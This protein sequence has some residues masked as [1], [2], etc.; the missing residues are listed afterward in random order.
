MFDFRRIT[1][2]CL[3]KRLSKHKWPYFLK[4][5]RAWPLWP[6]GY[7]CVHNPGEH[8]GLTFWNMLTLNYTRKENEHKVRKKLPFFNMWLLYVQL[9]AEQNRYGLVW[10]IMINQPEL[11]M[12][13]MMHILQAQV[14]GSISAHPA[15][16]NHKTKGETSDASNCQLNQA[17]WNR[18]VLKFGSENQLNAHNFTSIVFLFSL[19]RTIWKKSRHYQFDWVFAAHLEYRPL[20]LKN[21]RLL[22]FEYVK[23]TVVLTKKQVLKH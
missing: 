5:W 15:L 21:V 14:C 4:I 3:E 22:A 18:T 20:V 1:L 13:E 11:T 16:P 19:A 10:A 2:F 17:S 8:P 6:P 12:L 23:T 7:A 9:L